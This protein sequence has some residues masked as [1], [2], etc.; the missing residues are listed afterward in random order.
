MNGTALVKLYH[1][2]IDVAEHAEDA[3]S[4]CVVIKMD[5]ADTQEWWGNIEPENV[6]RYAIEARNLAVTIKRLRK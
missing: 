3:M 4:D 5:E 6:V 2:E 1:N